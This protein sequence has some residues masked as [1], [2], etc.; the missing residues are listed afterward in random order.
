L[1]S[2]IVNIVKPLLSDVFLFLDDIR[3]PEQTYEYTKQEM[4]LQQKWEV[5]R[6]FDEFK[7]HVENNG[8]PKF[9]SFDHDLADTNS[10]PEHL[11]NENNASKEGQKQQFHQEKT[12]YDCAMWLVDYCIDNHLKLPEYFCHSMNP[13]GREKII[14]L[15]KS[16]QN[17]R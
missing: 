2:T 5:V 7:S 14:G 16:F 11:P 4:F 12:G 15:L 6:N 9:I 1:E 8:L 13:V 3:E 17:S 10:T